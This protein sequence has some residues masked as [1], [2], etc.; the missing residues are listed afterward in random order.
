MKPALVRIVAFND[1]VPAFPEFG[2]LDIM[3]RPI[4]GSAK[5]D[6]APFAPSNPRC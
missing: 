1:L 4:G 6:K 5:N 3:L 2:P